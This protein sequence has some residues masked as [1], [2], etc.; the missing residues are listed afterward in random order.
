MQ[1][2]QEL[3]PRRGQLRDCV[4]G[5]AGR[6]SERGQRQDGHH[7]RR[8]DQQVYLGLL[9]VGKLRSWSL[10]SSLLSEGDRSKG[11]G[12]QRGPH[13]EGRRRGGRSFQEGERSH[14]ETTLQLLLGQLFLGRQRPR[15]SLEQPTG[16][17]SVPL[18]TK[19]PTA[20]ESGMSSKSRGADMASPALQVTEGSALPEG[21]QSQPSSRQSVVPPRG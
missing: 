6:S 15:S 20:E 9:K 5:A 13:P 11:G 7:G 3:P 10:G 4:G 1:Q 21:L 14:L 2:E 18:F 8:E 12:S 16:A 19:P 17:D